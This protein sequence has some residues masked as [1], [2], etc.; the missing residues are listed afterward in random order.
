MAHLR[1]AHP[2]PIKRT[3]TI[4][5]KIY[6]R[7]SFDEDMRSIVF[8]DT[9][10][11]KRTV[12]Q[13]RWRRVIVLSLRVLCYRVLVHVTSLPCTSMC[14]LSLIMMMMTMICLCVVYTSE[15]SCFITQSLMTLANNC[16]THYTHQLLIVN[17]THNLQP[18]QIICRSFQFQFSISFCVL[19]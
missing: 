17:S 14:L 15:R 9:R 19:F 2:L 8:T 16:S 12:K 18:Q 1:V 6:L 5:R 11:N 4:C 7:W 10:R 13:R 3:S